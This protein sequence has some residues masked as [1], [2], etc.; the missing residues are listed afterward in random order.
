M[1]GGA[2]ASD[3]ESIDWD[4]RV[5]LCQ[6]AWRAITELG[7][8][9]DEKREPLRLSLPMREVSDIRIARQIFGTDALQNH[10]G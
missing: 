3:D 2:C 7:E 5:G 1:N 10:F 9:K 6:W 4:T 8:D